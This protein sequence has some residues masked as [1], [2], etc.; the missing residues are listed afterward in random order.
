M[1]IDMLIILKVRHLFYNNCQLM[2]SLEGIREVPLPSL[3]F[4]E[5]FTKDVSFRFRNK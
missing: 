4:L 5:T 3:L 2:I 1:V